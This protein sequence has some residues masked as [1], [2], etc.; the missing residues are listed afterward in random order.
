MNQ[1]PLNN[2]HPAKYRQKTSKSGIVEV[3]GNVIAMNIDRLMSMFV[4][5]IWIL[6]FRYPGLKLWGR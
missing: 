5:L 1:S 2:P 4:R 6:M 3:Q